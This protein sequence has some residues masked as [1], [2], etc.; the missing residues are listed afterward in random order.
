MIAYISLTNLNPFFCYHHIA[1]SALTLEQPFL[2]VVCAQGI[3][4]A[5]VARDIV[6]LG[7]WMGRIDDHH[8]VVLRFTLGAEFII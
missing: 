1:V 6:A 8:L 2:E 5:F 4:M 7:E 3:G